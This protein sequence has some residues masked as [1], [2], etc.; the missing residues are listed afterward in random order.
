MS[1]R[2]D[3]IDVGSVVDPIGQTNV[4][5]FPNHSRAPQSR[6]GFSCVNGISPMR[7]RIAIEWE[8][9]SSTPRIG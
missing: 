4:T 9:N 8:D 5:P 1:L 2:E 3:I 7:P 6:N